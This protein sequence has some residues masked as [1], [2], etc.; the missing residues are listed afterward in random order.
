VAKATNEV[1]QANESR[2]DAALSPRFT[3]A[4]ARRE[5]GISAIPYR[6]WYGR[7]TKVPVELQQVFMPLLQPH[8][9]RLQRGEISRTW[10]FVPEV[11]FIML[12]LKNGEIWATFGDVLQRACL[13]L[14]L[15]R[16]RVLA[17][18]YRTFVRS[19]EGGM[20]VWLPQQPVFP[21]DCRLTLPCAEYQA[22]FLGKK[23]TFVVAT[24]RSAL[25]D[26]QRGA[27]SEENEPL[28][29]P[30]RARVQRAP[31]ALPIGA[32]A[33]NGFPA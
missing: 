8:L 9:E 22:N 33:G 10:T 30:F 15:L 32:G 13:L 14:Q 19:P 23:P 28:A 6:H 3:P 17:L 18:R 2:A 31:T 20:W 26:N 1:K 5:A 29:N 25:R 4:S 12:Q 7:F 21:P 24:Y 11:G 27:K 16:R